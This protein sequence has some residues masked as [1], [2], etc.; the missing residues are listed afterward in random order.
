MSPHNKVIN[1]PAKENV[2]NII[3]KFHLITQQSLCTFCDSQ[4]ENSHTIIFIINKILSC[5]CF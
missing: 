1:T 2:K 3:L 4:I 5:T